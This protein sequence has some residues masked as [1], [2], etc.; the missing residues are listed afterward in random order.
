MVVRYR[1][2]VVDSPGPGTPP[3]LS[4]LSHENEINSTNWGFRVGPVFRF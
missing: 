3:N 1:S 4:F 2:A